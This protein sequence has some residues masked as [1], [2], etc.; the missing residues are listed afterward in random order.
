MILYTI[1]YGLWPP[2]KRR[3]GLLGSLQQAGVRLLIDTRH[4]P[5]ASQLDPA[6]SYGPRDWHLQA[7]GGIAAQLANHGIDYRWLVELGNPQKTD[8]AMAVLLA[9]LN[10]R[11]ERWPINRGVALLA[12]ILGETGPCALLCACADY[13]QCHRTVVAEAARER[14]PELDIEIAHL[15][16]G[17]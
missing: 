1:G 2:A 3:A 14:F 7:D 6:N 17:G 4:S 5:C 8:P 16:A 9:H 11:N 13:R 10:S 15:P 12:K